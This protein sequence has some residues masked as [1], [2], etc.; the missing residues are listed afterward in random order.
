M[1]Y[2]IRQSEDGDIWSRDGMTS[3]AL[4]SLTITHADAA[5]ETDEGRYDDSPEDLFATRV[6]LPEER[7]I[8]AMRRL[9]AWGI[10]VDV[11]DSFRPA[12]V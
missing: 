9:M 6:E 1:I 8:G 11:A 2:E 7:F 5:A 12:R 10:S 3:I 4:P